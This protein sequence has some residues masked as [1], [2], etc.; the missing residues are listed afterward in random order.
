MVG[1]GGSDSDGDDARAAPSRRPCTS[2]VPHRH[3]RTKGHAA[4][5]WSSVSVAAMETMHRESTRFGM[6]P[7]DRVIELNEK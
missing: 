6:T 5:G 2:P 3:P 7:I 1:G 4:G